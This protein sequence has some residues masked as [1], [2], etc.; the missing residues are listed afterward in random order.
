MLS[1]V[2]LASLS[3]KSVES[4]PSNATN[5]TK[6]QEDC[7][8]YLQPVIGDAHKLH[9]PNNNQVVTSPINPAQPLWS[10]RSAQQAA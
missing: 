10:S 6:I 4:T 8:A 2:K 3:S 1:T 9:E 5:S 7:F